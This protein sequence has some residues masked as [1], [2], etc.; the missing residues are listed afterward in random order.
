MIID[1]VTYKLNM[2]EHKQ[3]GDIDA[4][5][6]C[7]VSYKSK[8]KEIA[9]RLQFIPLYLWQIVK[10]LSDYWVWDDGRNEC[11]LLDVDEIQA[12]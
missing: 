12:A 11:G 7:D 4:Q 3:F 5:R 1:A 10:A 6:L 2:S 8:I 9:W